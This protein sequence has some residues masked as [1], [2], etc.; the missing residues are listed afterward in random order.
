M[1]LNKNDENIVR[2]AKAQSLKKVVVYITAGLSGLL[3][4]VLAIK[5]DW[6]VVSILFLSGLLCG[7]AIEKYY[8]RQIYALCIKFYHALKIK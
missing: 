5:P 7:L 3:F 8:S 6:L 4:V 1:K 2:N